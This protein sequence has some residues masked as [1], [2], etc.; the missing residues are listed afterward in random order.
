MSKISE[1]E[2]AEI[3][4][5]FLATWDGNLAPTS[6]LKHWLEHGQVAT[7]YGEFRGDPAQLPCDRFGPDHHPL[8][9][10]ACARRGCTGCC[11]CV[12]VL[13]PVYLEI[14]ILTPLAWSPGMI[15]DRSA[16]DPWRRDP[17]RW[18]AVDELKR[19]VHL[20]LATSRKAQ[21]WHGGVWRVVA[22]HY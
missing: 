2:V 12:G 9:P 6:W 22:T 16:L 10:S 1:A 21:V 13:L 4:Q 18:V 8:G 14:R 17:P 5:A 11:F 19:E 15:C 7:G 3:Q 20:L